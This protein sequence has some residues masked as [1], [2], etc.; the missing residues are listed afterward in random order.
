MAVADLQGLTKPDD[1]ALAWARFLLNDIV[2]QREAQ[3]RPV[4]PGVYV[5]GMEGTT[6]TVPSV[7][8]TFDP[9]DPSSLEGLI[10]RHEG[11]Y[12]YLAVMPGLPI[13]KSEWGCAPTPA[14]KKQLLGVPTQIIEPGDYPWFLMAYFYS[15]SCQ[16]TFCGAFDGSKFRE[17]KC[18]YGTYGGRLP[19]LIAQDN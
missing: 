1:I 7:P 18:I 19:S 11:A 2:E 10:G 8:E 5:F 3:V 12:A 13:P 4:I 6:P 14:A 15:P 9:E 16:M 17:I